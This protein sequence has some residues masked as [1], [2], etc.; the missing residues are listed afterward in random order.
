[1]TMM[2]E[3]IITRDALY[4]IS[5]METIWIDYDFEGTSQSFE[6][7]VPRIRFDADVTI[8][9][10]EVELFHCPYANYIREVQLEYNGNTYIFEV[11]SC[12]CDGVVNSHMVDISTPAGD[13]V[14]GKKYIISQRI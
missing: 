9:L 4:L 13:G 1:M 10:D 3:S 8:V 5:K 14:G 11:L 7:K 12:V 2:N 6:A